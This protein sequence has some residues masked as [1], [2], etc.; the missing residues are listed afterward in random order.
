MRITV[1]GNAKSDLTGNC[2]D[3]LISKEGLSGAAISFSKCFLFLAQES[4][5]PR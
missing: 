2:E 3:S 1:E 4:E 5:S